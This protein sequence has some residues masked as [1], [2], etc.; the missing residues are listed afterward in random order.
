M[1]LNSRL[2]Q[3]APVKLPHRSFLIHPWQTLPCEVHHPVTESSISHQR[4]SFLI[5]HD[6]SM[7]VVWRWFWVVTGPVSMFY[8][9]YRGSRQLVSV[10]EWAIQLRH[11]GSSYSPH[12]F[13][14]PAGDLGAIYFV[15]PSTVY[16][17]LT[18]LIGTAPSTIRT[19]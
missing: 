15:L 5:R 3:S 10:S 2:V 4:A 14:P 16:K 7:G 12:L 13:S 9:D 6:F 1:I 11:L 8:G 18:C 17:A 19:M